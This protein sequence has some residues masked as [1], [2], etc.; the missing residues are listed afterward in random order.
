MNR[1]KISQT[2][3]GN[4]DNNQST[5]IIIMMTRMTI[6]IRIKRIRTIFK[7][8]IRILIRITQKSG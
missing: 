5:I 6:V 8:V 4:E 7:K 3:N 1:N 2:E